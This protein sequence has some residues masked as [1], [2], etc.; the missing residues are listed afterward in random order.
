MSRKKSQE[1]QAATREGRGY[2]Y[3]EHQLWMLTPPWMGILALAALGGLLHRLL[4]DDMIRLAWGVFGLTTATV[5]ITAAAAIIA[6]PRGPITRTLAMAGTIGGGLWLIVATIVGVTIIG[7]DLAALGAAATLAIIT[8]IRRLLRGQGDDQGHQGGKDW[9]TLAG[10]VKTLRSR[11]RGA[12][13]EGA[14]RTITLDLPDGMSAAEAQA[15]VPRLAAT[16]RVPATGVRMTPDPDDAGRV[17]LSITPEDMLKHTVH[18]PGPT[19]AGRSI[20]E[21]IGLGVYEDGQGLSIRLP[22]IP[23]RQAMSHILVVGMTGAGKSELLQVL[24]GTAGTRIDVVIDYIDVAGKAEQTVGPIRGAIRR[25]VTD[26]RDG[27]AYLRRRLAEVPDRARALAAVGMREWAEGAPIPFEIVIIDEGSS[28]VSD[29]TDFVEMVRLLRSVGIL[30]VLAVQRATFDQMPTSARANFGT[31]ACF[32]VRS[33]RDA[34]AALSP[35]TL[36]AGAAP[37]AWRNRRPGYLYL[38][39]PGVPGER[40]A[41]PAR[42]YLAQAADIERILVEAAPLRLGATTTREVAMP[43][44][45]LDDA[46]EPAEIIDSEQPQAGEET[47]RYRPADALAEELAAADPDAELG[48]I[49]DMDQRIGPPPLVP[50]LTPAQ[51]EEALHEFL[52]EFQAI[53]R[54][55]FSRRDLIADG[56]LQVTNR[57]KSWLSGQLGRM[58][59]AGNLERIGEREDG[60]YAWASAHTGSNRT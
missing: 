19:A 51:A 45:A 13:T 59:D 26:R 17:E 46:G 33:D 27:E 36:D 30:I 5:T 9:E 20:A 37:H 32:G 42:A 15:D 49:P 1:A 18:W 57:S 39:A 53:N 35:E 40:Y 4:A 48:E 24:V 2:Q 28:L 25:L 16:L 22:G 54:G 8:N 44:R 10:D 6:R 29:S 14:T 23:G 38:E 55:Q 47:P 11:I 3:I 58:V 56:I 41:M 7:L 52:H 43:S 12:R 31:V 60:V 34:A 21:P 50:P